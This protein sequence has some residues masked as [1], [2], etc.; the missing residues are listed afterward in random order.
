ME[1]MELSELMEAINYLD[2]WVKGEVQNDPPPPTK[3]EEDVLCEGA[4]ASEVE[5]SVVKTEK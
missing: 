5:S 2:Q 1:D 3:S 4:S